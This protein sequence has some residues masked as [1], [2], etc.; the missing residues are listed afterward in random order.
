MLTRN[1]ITV[2]LFIAVA[3]WGVALW[4]LGVPITLED[5][6]P[7]ALTATILSSACLVFD[8]WLW[9]F[10]I[11]SGWLVQRPC[12]HGTWKVALQ[13]SWIDSKTQRQVEPIVG[14]VTMRQTFSR[15]SLR[16]FTE[17]SSSFLVA[18]KLILLE[19]GIFQLTGVFQNIPDVHLRGQRSEIHYGA[20]LL[21]VRGDPP[22]GLEGHYWTDRSTRGSM[23]LSDRRVKVVSNYTEGAKLY[24]F[25]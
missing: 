3:T 2:L 20:I 6:K 11:F 4:L 13:S 17:E 25:D 14:V 9:Q 8:R 7:F 24:R 15:L 23:R 22:V 21:E 10:R 18:H 1:Q 16:L 12:V 5:A 19:D